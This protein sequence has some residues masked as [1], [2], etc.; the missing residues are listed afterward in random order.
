[1]RAFDGAERMLDR[2]ATLTHLLWM[3]IE[4]ALN[5]FENVLVF[6]SR[7]AALFAGGAL[8]FDGTIRASIGPVAA[9]HQP[10]FFIGVTIGEPFTGGTDVDVL[11]SHLTEVLLAKTPFRLCI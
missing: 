2:L 4:P 3:L 5:R 1:M 7:D 8:R 10:V 11:F 6:P 9:Q